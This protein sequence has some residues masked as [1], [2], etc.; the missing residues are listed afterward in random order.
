MADSHYLPLNTSIILHLFECDNRTLPTTQNDIL[1]RVVLIS[2]KRHLKE[3]TELENSSLEKL[4]S[5]DDLSK[6]VKEPFQFLCKLAYDGMKADK[7]DLL[8]D[9][10]ILGLLYS[11]ESFAAHGKVVSHYT[12]PISLFRSS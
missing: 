12:F 1:S 3:Q 11:V 10:N 4:K 6:V 5:L 9:F 2:V 8:L 7:V